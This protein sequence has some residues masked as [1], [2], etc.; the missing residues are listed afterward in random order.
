WTPRFLRSRSRKTQAE[1]Y[2][3][4]GLVAHESG[5]QTSCHGGVRGALDDGPAVGEQRDLV[6]LAPELQDKVVMLD[7]AVGLEAPAHLRKI[8]RPVLL[9]DL[10]RVSAAQRNLRPALSGQVDKLML[11]ADL[12][13]GAGTLGRNLAAVVAPEIEGQQ[14]APQLVASTHQKL[15]GFRGLDGTDKV[16]GA[17]E[18][19]GGVT[20]L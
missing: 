11:A 15:H 17:V 16:D 7:G 14:R 1:P 6:R 4:P 5:V 8:H 19:T 2:I 12:A 20:S 3:A 18:D 10:H 9:V 13:A